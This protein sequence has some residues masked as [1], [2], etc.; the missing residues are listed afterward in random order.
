MSD[1]TNDPV[2]NRHALVR[3]ARAL[4]HIQ[5]AQN[6]LAR[7]CAELSP[8]TNGGMVLWKRTSRQ[9]DQVKALWYALDAVREDPR[10]AGRL[11]LDREPAEVGGPE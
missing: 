1:G 5:Q 8:I 11:G 6:L 9:H 4:D 7:A 2:R 10:R 3:V